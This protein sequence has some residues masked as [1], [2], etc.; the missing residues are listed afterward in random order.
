MNRPSPSSGSRACRI[1]GL[2]RSK[3]VLPVRSAYLTV[4]G[5]LQTWTVCISIRVEKNRY[6]IAFSSQISSRLRYAAWSRRY[7]GNGSEGRT[8]N[9]G[10]KSNNVPP[11]SLM[12]PNSRTGQEAAGGR[13]RG[14]PVSQFLC[15]HQELDRMSRGWRCKKGIDALGRQVAP[16]QAEMPRPGIPEQAVRTEFRCEAPHPIN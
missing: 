13:C 14:A 3:L 11:T 1:C 10:I 8:G 15:D 6:S 5:L 2:L 7:G 12:I 16:E 4:A 9:G